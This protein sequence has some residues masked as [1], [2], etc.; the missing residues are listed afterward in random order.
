MILFKK[1]SLN[2]DI[3]ADH[4]YGTHKRPVFI[5]L[6]R[7]SSEPWIVNQATFFSPRDRCL[8][9]VF[10]SSFGSRFQTLSFASVRTRL[11]APVP[12][13][14]K[15]QLYR[16]SVLDH[17]PFAGNARNEPRTIRQ[18]A[19]CRHLWQSLLLNTLAICDLD[20]PP[21]PVGPNHGAAVHNRPGTNPGILADP[22]WIVLTP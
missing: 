22:L 2:P 4:H 15:T 11:H 8:V 18:F 16:S 17:G 6:S 21:A 10:Q 3:S 13:L 7:H 14:G 20:H 12:C 5:C 1:T 19:P 9:Y